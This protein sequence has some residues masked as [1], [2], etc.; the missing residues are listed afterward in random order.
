[1]KYL[2]IIVTILLVITALD[3]YITGYIESS[4][5]KMLD[6][7]KTAQDALGRNDMDTV[8]RQIEAMR[9]EWETDESRWEVFT[10]HRETENVD[11]LLTRLEGMAAANTPETMLPEFQELQFFLQHITE[12]QKFRPENIL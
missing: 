3:L 1:M 6:I 10:D 5:E 8:N 4:A 7:I 9:R 12:K 11:T 2:V